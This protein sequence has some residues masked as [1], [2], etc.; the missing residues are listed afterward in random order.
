MGQ[1]LFSSIHAKSNTLQ[2]DLM[3]GLETP[4]HKILKKILSSI[5]SMQRKFDQKLQY[6]RRKTTNSH[7]FS[8]SQSIFMI[9]GVKVSY[10]N[11][12]QTT[13]TF[14]RFVLN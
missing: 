7:N 10:L 6:S 1:K 3:I 8:K 13:M 12:I 14:I 5:G 9:F 4:L 2:S 11:S